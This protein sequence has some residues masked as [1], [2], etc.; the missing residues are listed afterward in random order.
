MKN[1]YELSQKDKNKYRD[2]FNK[3]DYA[4]RL[5]MPRVVSAI[6]VAISIFG[7]NFMEIMKEEESIN[8][9]EF[10]EFLFSIGVFAIISFLIYQIIYNVS[11]YRWMKIKKD[12]EY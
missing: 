1:L 7:Y 12:I 4:K 3:L 9:G 10:P 5:Y 11:F 2:E 8:F 6:V